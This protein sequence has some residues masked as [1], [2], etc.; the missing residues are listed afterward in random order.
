MK[1]KL[2]LLLVTIIATVC[3][4]NAQTTD[5]TGTW[6]LVERGGQSIPAEYSMLKMI[7]PT[8]F[9]W[10]IA[11]PEGNIINGAGGAYTLVGNKYTESIDMVL[12][13]MK[14]FYK[15]KAV[16]DVKVTGNKMVITGLV[17][18]VENKET[19]EKVK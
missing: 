4:A 8:H 2:S 3:M 12:P 18:E 10:T 14:S 19:W 15:S 13:G 1:R 5:I 17:G 11:D 7:T 9:M 16:Y 6:K